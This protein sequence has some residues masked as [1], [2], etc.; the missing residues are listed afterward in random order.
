MQVAM[1]LR[2]RVMTRVEVMNGF[3]SLVWR[4]AL[5]CSVNSM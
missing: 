2:T 5:A 1:R 4:S 3:S